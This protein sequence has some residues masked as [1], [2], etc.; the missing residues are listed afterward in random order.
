MGH[1][2]EQCHRRVNKGRK[3]WV[4][5]VVQSTTTLAPISVPAAKETT[6]APEVDVEGFVLA[7]AGFSRHRCNQLKPVQTGNSFMELHTSDDNEEE[8][9]LNRR[10]KQGEVRRFIASH[11]I[12]MF[13][14]L[15]TRVKAPRMG[16]MYL[17][18]CP[19]WCFSTNLSCHQNGRI[20]IAWDPD[21]FMVDIVLMHTEFMHCFVTPR[22]TGTGFHCTF[23]Y[24]LHDRTTK[25]SLWESLKAI[26][27]KC[28]EA[29][30]IMGD[31]NALM[32]LED[33]IGS[34][35]RTSKIQP[36]RSCMNYCQLT[37]VKTVGRFYTW[38]NKQ[39]GAYR[40][41][42]RIDRVLANTKWGDL[43]YS[44][45]AAYLREGDFDH[46][47]MVLNCYQKSP[48]KRPFR[49][50]NMWTSSPRFHTI[51]DTNWGKYVYGRPM[52]RVLQKLKGINVDLKD[53]NREGYSDVETEHYRCHKLLIET[54]NH[55]HANPGNH[56][57]AAE[58]KTV[59]TEYR[60][61]KDNYLSYLKQTAKIHWLQNGDENT[62]SFH[63][64]IR[65]RRKHNRIQSIHDNSANWIQ[66]DSGAQG[67]FV[68][69]YKSLFFS[70]IENRTPILSSIMDR[71][72]RLTDD[73]RRKLECSFTV[74][75]IKR[76]LDDIPSF[77]APGM[78][79]FNNHF[80]K[81]AWDIISQNQGA[82][83]AGRSILHNV[84]VCQDIVKMYRNSQHVPCCLMKLDLQ[85]A[86]DT[87]EWSFLEE[88]MTNLGFPVHFIN[89]VMTCLTTTHYSVLINGVPTEL[90]QPTRGWIQPTRGEH[91]HF[92]FH[93]RCK[94][95]S[96]NHLCFAD[97]LLMFCRGDPNVVSVMLEGFKIFSS[98]TG[99]EVN[100]AKSSIY[101][102][103]ISQENRETISQVYGFKFGTL[104][105]KYLGVPIV[106][107]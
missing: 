39:D 20:V 52:Y 82:F 23:I 4:P 99:L 27:D 67:A 103:G 65:Q 62:K 13:S 49:F 93:S 11:H 17:N 61:A 10:D 26:A 90:I 41:F 74:E 51:V 19:S 68:Q 97:D 88:V 44:A 66:T 33:R 92:R 34:T 42:S 55:L 106:R 30:I 107:L 63:Q 8:L 70:N 57:L 85:K 104:P 94:L 22:S 7:T 72:R 31:F 91:P 2:Q 21:A 12:K 59:A 50:Y 6:I 5:K 64:S 105:F 18:V 35:V 47:P 84:L 86:Y 100:A 38:N 25:E 45:E 43:Y 87:V 58:E 3:Q 77:K 1:T 78:D 37:E 40:V 95:L 76:V 80:F 73:H 81:E 16:D 14:L 53:L 60:K 69:F 54:Q 56:D 29:W 46:C 102:C 24:G 48:Q 98:T 15:E 36:M 89:L 79:G 32:D 9:G 83:V 96:L 101:C 28:K 75:D 71:G